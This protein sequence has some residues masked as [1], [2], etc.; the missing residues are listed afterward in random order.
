[1][2]AIFMVCYIVNPGLETISFLTQKRNSIMASNS[3]ICKVMSTAVI[4]GSAPN[5]E[6]LADPKI[7][8]EKGVRRLYTIAG[9]VTGV[10]SKENKFGQIGNKYIGDFEAVN[11][12]TGESFV[13]SAYFAASTLDAILTN[14]LAKSDGKGAQFGVVVGLKANEK[15]ATKYE[16]VVHPIVPIKENDA[17]NDLRKAMADVNA[18]AKK[19]KKKE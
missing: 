7:L 6:M 8:D 5:K 13:S 1:M 15:S 9:V 11:L 17:M 18:T 10:K 19:A 12:E 4:M 2:L 16:Y 3:T 14:Q